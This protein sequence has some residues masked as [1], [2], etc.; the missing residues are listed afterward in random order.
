MS[1]DFKNVTNLEGE[2]R[3]S[4]S[5]IASTPKWTTNWWSRTRTRERNERNRFQRIWP[6]WK[7]NRLEN[8]KLEGESGLLKLQVYC[9]TIWSA[10]R[11]ESELMNLFRIISISREEG[12]AVSAMMGK[13]AKNEVCNRMLHTSVVCGRNQFIATGR[14]GVGRETQVDLP[15]INSQCPVKIQTQTIDTESKKLISSANVNRPQKP[16]DSLNE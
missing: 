10:N 6:F 14:E 12:K 7:E 5:M 4:S 2:Q 8:V 13:K 15:S 16:K 9:R 1:A 11:F 3:S